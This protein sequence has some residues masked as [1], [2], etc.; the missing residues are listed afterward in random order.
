MAPPGDITVLLHRWQAGDKGAL[1]D[2][3]PLIY[4][5]LKAIAGSLGRHQSINFGLQATALVNEAFLR[6]IGQQ[7]LGWEGREH[8]FSLAALAMRQILTDAARSQLAVKRGGTNRRVPLH[9]DMQ[10]VSINH[11]EMVDL[12]LALE[13]LA[14]FDA[15]K[16]RVVELRYFLGCTAEEAADVLGISRATVDRET[17]VARA[18]LFRRLKGVSMGRPPTEV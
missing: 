3:M 5:R 12:N 18:W 16:V 10:W 4:P 15:R 9:E 11:E 14:E 2:L 17:N 7:R 8:F 1:D 6:L 13:E